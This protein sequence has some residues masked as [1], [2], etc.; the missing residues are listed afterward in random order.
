M[1]A[2]NAD[3]YQSHLKLGAILATLKQQ[4]RAA[5]ILAR[6]IYIYPFNPTLHEEL[7]VL[8]EEMQN[9][10]LA[11][12]ARESVLALAPV[13]MAEAHYRLAFAYHRAGDGQA[14]RYQVLRA[15]ERAPSFP[16]ALELLLELHGSASPSQGNP[17]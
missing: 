2:I 6:A 13:D 10:P 7:A 4:Q 3:H 5:D 9:W 16:K 1:V 14:A 8:Y 17:D 12:Q 11:A 15:L